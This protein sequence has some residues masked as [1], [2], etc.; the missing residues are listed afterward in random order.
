MPTTIGESLPRLPQ[1]VVEDLDVRRRALALMRDVTVRAE[2]REAIDA[3]GLKERR[4]QW[5]RTEGRRGIE[6]AAQDI[7]ALLA[8]GASRAEATL[9]PVFL[10]ELIDELCADGTGG[11]RLAL[12]L[13]NIVRD[14]EEDA[15]HGRALAEAET[16]EQMCERARLLRLEGA[17]KLALARRLEGDARRRT[18][19][20]LRRTA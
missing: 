13:E 3:Q 20:V 11:D 8:A 17:A 18:L 14:A 4:H 1:L 7:A 6:I 9:L 16:P 5:L 12:E 10:M 2:V 19:A 15:L